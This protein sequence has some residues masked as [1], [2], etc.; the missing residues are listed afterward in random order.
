MPPIIERR[1]LKPVTESAAQGLDGVEAGG[2]PTAD[3]PDGPGFASCKQGDLPV[4]KSGLVD[5]IEKALCEAHERNRSSPGGPLT[6]IVSSA[7]RK[8]FETWGCR[9]GRLSRDLQY[10]AGHVKPGTDQW[11][12]LLRRMTLRTVTVRVIPLLAGL[13]EAPPPHAPHSPGPLEGSPGSGCRSTGSTASPPPL[14]GFTYWQCCV[15][16]IMHISNE[17]GV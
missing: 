5:E 10:Q 16:A 7:K 11:T 4:G 8:G 9:A 12:R 14:R 6:D 3:V 13:P 1:Q 15:Y 17:Q 2:S